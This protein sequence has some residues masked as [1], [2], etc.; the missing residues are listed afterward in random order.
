VVTATNSAGQ[1]SI[2]TLVQIVDVP[3]SGLAAEN[4]SPTTLSGSTQLTATITGGTNVT[5]AWVFGDGHDGNGVIVSHQYAAPGAYTATV[6][7][8]NSFGQ[9]TATTLVQITD[10]P[11]SG[12]TASN[13]SPTLVGIATQLTATV[14][15]GSNVTYVWDLGDGNS[16]NGAEI[17]H[18]YTAPGTYT[19]TV[20][21]VNSAGQLSA[22]TVVQVKA[23]AF[24]LYLPVILKP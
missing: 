7:A 2:S 10:V 1:Q 22:P 5:Y 8:T 14:S 9:E 15:S 24:S 11:I 23:L 17:T 13:D 12:L 16:D 20:T 6:T 4:D 3:I 18:Q 21:A 19:A